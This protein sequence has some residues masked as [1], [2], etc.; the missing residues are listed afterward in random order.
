MKLIL[1][2]VLAIWG[3]P[4]MAHSSSD[5][6]INLE[7]ETS[8]KYRL[9]LRIHLIDLHRRFDLDYGGDRKVSWGELK[10]ARLAIEAYLIE[11]VY[12]GS[13]EKSCSRWL[14]KELTL[15]RQADG[16]FA[17]FSGHVECSAD[18]R[19]LFL[20]YDAFFDID[21]QHRGF[22]RF[23]SIDG[24][25][26]AILSQDAREIVLKEART[27]R[28]LRFVR[29][30]VLHI[31]TGYDHILFILS[32]ILPAVYFRQN[33]RWAPHRKFSDASIPLIKALTAF[34]ISHS[35]A[36]VLNSVGWLPEMSI[37]WV[38]AGIAFSI[39]FTALNNI[40]GWITG[41]EVLLAFGFGLLHGLGLSSM[42]NDLG[43]GSSEM[44]TGLL[45][46]NLGIELAQI[47][48]VM[49]VVP[50]S[51]AFRQIAT[52]R[53]VVLEAGSIATA[54]LAAVWLVERVFEIS[55]IS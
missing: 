5:A 34:T 21:A 48:I 22:F 44:I 41:R 35:M 38:E 54:V 37:K 30:G 24:E 49:V 46:F 16:M 12:L 26:A 3:T 2:L 9:D 25:T 55:I 17:K 27:Q 52:F 53:L 23:A 10:A 19:S 14:P 47:A 32:I 4:A 20:R 1:W 28:F 7:Q 29:E 36:L 40:F 13:R 45:G 43:L 33:G 31:A 39:V 8:S 11:R 6:F 51:Y 50:I 15:E 42:F 18:I